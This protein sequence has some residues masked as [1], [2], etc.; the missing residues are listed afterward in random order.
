[1]LLSRHTRRREFITLIGGAAAAWPLAARAQQRKPMRR[2]GALMP[3]AANDPHMQ[4]RNAAFL[5]GMQRLGWTVGDNVQI[6]YR[7]SGGNEEDTRK[8]AAELVALAPEVIFTS[9]SAGVEPLRRVTRTVPIVFAL[10]PDPVG[11]GIVDS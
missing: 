8:Y 4:I 11:A 9:G 10:V 2:V 5:Q 3:Y 1:M 6:D 7:W